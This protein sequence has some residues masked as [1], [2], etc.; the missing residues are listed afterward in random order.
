MKMLSISHHSVV[1]TSH[2]TILLI[3]LYS[4]LTH[5]LDRNLD[6]QDQQSDAHTGP[7]DSSQDDRSSSYD[8]SGSSETHEYDS[9]MPGNLPAPNEL[10]VIRLNDTSVVLRWEIPESAQDHLL[11]F[12][13]QYRSTRKTPANWHT[14]P[15]QIPPTTR[16]HQIN[17]LRPGNYF[18]TVSAVYDNDDN[19]L[20][21][22]FKFKLRARSKIKQEE[23]PEMTAPKIHWSEA[24]HD[25]FRLKWIYEPKDKDFDSFGFLV[26]FRSNHVVGTDFIIYN[27]LDPS[28]EVAEVEPNT[29]YE[30]MVVAYNSV[31][32]SNFS[33]IVTIRT[34]PNITTTSPTS[35]DETQST[36][37]TTLVPSTTTTTTSTRKPSWTSVHGQQPEDTAAATP[38]SNGNHPSINTTPNTKVPQIITSQDINSTTSIITKDI[39]QQITN[40][41]NA[42]LGDQSDAMLITRYLVLVLLPIIIIV[43]IL[44]C[45][46]R[47]PSV[48]AKQDDASIG[49]DNSMQF[50]LEINGYFKNSFPN[51]EEE[52]SP[53]TNHTDIGQGFINNH[54]N[55]KDFA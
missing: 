22:Q 42:I 35:A 10:S 48:S 14:E 49:T 29:P 51:V 8:P 46:M 17:G 12:R 20:S 28:V 54:P 6:I 15:D 40:V 31:T 16:A 55:I 1:S 23:L 53:D 26:Y 39:Y 47:G 11:N 7:Q 4:H 32:A 33:D 36:S 30:V 9:D 37:K 52:Y 38:T 21:Q 19:S 18:F 45:L 24:K 2:Y 41:F 27:T 25:F 13:V 43:C 50:H 5:S 44:V 3:L 34:E